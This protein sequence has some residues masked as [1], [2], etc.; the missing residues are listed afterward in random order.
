MKKPESSS[1]PKGVSRDVDGVLP[2]APD[3]L[4]TG[5]DY[6]SLLSRYNHNL[7]ELYE[8]ISQI[9]DE[10][11]PEAV[12]QL[13]FDN[14]QN[15]VCVAGKGGRMVY[16]NDYWRICFP[17]GD[18]SEKFEDYLSDA[19]ARAYRK[20]RKQ[21][22]GAGTRRLQCLYLSESADYLCFIPFSSSKH[23]EKF[24]L[25]FQF[26]RM[27]MIPAPVENR[28]KE[29][30][31]FHLALLQHFE[32]FCL[33]LDRKGHLVYL[34]E[35]INKYLGF[36][37]ADYRSDQ[38]RKLIRDISLS[39]A[40]EMLKIADQFKAY[41]SISSRGADVHLSH[42]NK[43]CRWF[44]MKISEIE[45]G[46]YLLVSFSDIHDRKL[47]E[48]NQENARKK[49]E[50]GDRMKS[51]FLANMSHEIRTPLNGIVGFSTML[52]RE[53]LSPEKKEK[54][55]RLIRSSTNQL[56]TLV[57]D[58]I[59]VTKIEAG[60]LRVS[61]KNVN[62]DQLLEELKAHYNQQVMITGKEDLV[63]RKLPV[64]PDMERQILTDETRLRQVF[65][66][67][68]DNAL[69]FTEEGEISF[70]YQPSQSKEITFFVRD[71]GRGIPKTQLKNIFK[72]FQ[73]TSE[74]EKEKYEGTGLGLFISKGIIELLGGH[75]HVSSQRGKGSEF[76]F[77]LPAVQ[78]D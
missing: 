73:Q 38:L 66:N 10:V 48:L 13:L 77:T 4:V 44:A 69:K 6:L 36:T 9:Q 23:K 62:I 21:Y 32:G 34:S 63:I 75:I 51:E 54:Y 7:V 47:N 61:T 22:E 31:K 15:P 56:L 55:L 19:D 70:G 65:I 67:L 49:A 68:M 11:D 2:E 64:E 37:A 27:S 41:H 52:D 71:T 30:V 40:R 16:R 60:Q 78:E 25:I 53:S 12:F 76:R 17:E 46:D 20:L 57:N 72:R 24:Q 26:D 18:E 42:K 14:L 39:E 3:M 1:K 8:K 50:A 33:V 43:Q 5:D 58:I 74:G 45:A 28:S 29:D 59:D 35:S